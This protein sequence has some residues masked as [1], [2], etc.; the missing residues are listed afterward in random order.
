MSD[1]RQSLHLEYLLLALITSAFAVL[2]G[3]AIAL[4]LLELR[5]KLPSQDLVYLGV[6]TAVT[7]S[8]VSLGMGARYLL[9]RL[10]LKPALLLR[11]PV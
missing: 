6:I 8:T 11:D 1:I 4:P 7:V 10:K 9:R 2:L 5:L 3:S